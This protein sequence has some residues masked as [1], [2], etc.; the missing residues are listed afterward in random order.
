MHERPTV[1]DF[2]LKAEAVDR[3]KGHVSIVDGS[4]VLKWHLDAQGRALL[5]NG[6]ER[7]IEQTKLNAMRDLVKAI[8]G[9][10]LNASS[11]A[12]EEH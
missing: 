1:K 11:K 2:H 6:D 5:L 7:T 12:P 10:V 8:L 9:P 4:A 3:V